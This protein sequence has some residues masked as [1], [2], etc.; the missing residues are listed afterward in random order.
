MNKNPEKL[1]LLTKS[2]TPW[3]VFLLLTGALVSSCSQ[4]STTT[5]ETTTTSVPADPTDEGS[6]RRTTTTTREITSSDRPDS[7]LGATA[8]AVGTIILFP[9]RLIGDAA[10]LIV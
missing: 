10:G 4:R 1:K 5:R 9:F 6:T 3:I 7:V 2:F 8:H